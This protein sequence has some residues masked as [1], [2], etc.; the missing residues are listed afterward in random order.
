M[1]YHNSSWSGRIWRYGPLGAWLVF[2]SYA[3]TGEFSSD[4]TSRFVRPF[5]LWLHP[6]ITEAQLAAVHLLTRKVAHFAE[7]GVLAFLA[8]RAFITSTSDFLR[9]HWFGVSLALVI[10]N[11]LIDELHQ[12]F[13]PDRSASIYDSAIDVLGGLTVLMV[14]KYFVER[15]RQPKLEEPERG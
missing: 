15:R 13:V 12:S 10:L 14:F 1:K 2:I 6:E 4:N 7:Y 11:A 8:R 5:L 3:S 9:R